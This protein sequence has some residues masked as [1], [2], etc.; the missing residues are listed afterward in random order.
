VSHHEEKKNPFNAPWHPNLFGDPFQKLKQH[1]KQ[2]LSEDR[3]AMESVPVSSGKEQIF[4]D[5]PLYV[6]TE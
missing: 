2:H 4:E 6:E 5:L 3:R 1:R